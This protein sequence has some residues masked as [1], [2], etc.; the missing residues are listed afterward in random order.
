MGMI[1]D[2]NEL[3]GKHRSIILMGPPKTGKSLFTVSGSRNAPDAIAKQDVDASDVVLLSVDTEGWLGASSF[4]YKPRVVDLSDAGGWAKLQ[5]HMADA[6][7]ELIPLTKSGEVSVVGLDLGAVGDE[8]IAYASGDM[9]NPGKGLVTLGA[10]HNNKDT[11]WSAVSAAGLQIHRAFRNLA[12]TVVVMTHTKLS[13]NNPYKGKED[14]D[15]QIGRDATAIGGE[16]G[17]LTSD[18]PKGIYKP[19][20]HN[21]S[22]ILA[23]DTDL[24][25]VGTALKPQLQNKYITYVGGGEG[26]YQTGNRAGGNL[27]TSTDKSLRYLLNLL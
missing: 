25:N 23:R 4:G 15:V 1:K 14:A 17:K 13:N 3:K 24:V 19:W 18:L 26:N 20:A 27:P 16:S 7:N 5:A 21:S 9:G 6:I 11:N 12:C 8:V 2:V 22:L 10:E